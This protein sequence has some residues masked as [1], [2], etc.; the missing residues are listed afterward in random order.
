MR[1]LTLKRVLVATDLEGDSG[2]VL[3]TAA[4]LAHLS[5]AELHLLHVETEP[6]PDGAA[7]LLEEFA[8]SAP[9]APEIASVRVLPGS[10]AEV[11]VAR[12]HDLDVDAVIL[13]PHRGDTTSADGLGSTAAMV[14]RTAT[15]PCLVAATELSLPMEHV[16]AAID[17]T[18]EASDVLGVALSWAS[19]LRP[20]A[21]VARLTALHVI[22]DSNSETAAGAVHEKVERIR[23]DSVPA[24]HVEIDERITAS[25]D[26]ADT[27]LREAISGASDLL[28][29]GTRAALKASA[30]LGSVSAAVARATRCPLLLVPPGLRA[31]ED[32]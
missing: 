27:I 8:R 20:R 6:T 22:A 5:G 26:P 25:P 17:L 30:E 21:Q 4:R 12:A 7:R 32:G 23:T 16:L 19:A 10:P 13:G 18:D 28:V 3:R 9:E 14:V 15:C 2:P 31:G 29:V 24:A 11:I 1:L